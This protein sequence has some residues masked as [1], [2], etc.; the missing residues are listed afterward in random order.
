MDIY[1]NGEKISAMLESEKTAFDVVESFSVLLN[2]DDIVVTSAEVDGTTFYMGDPKLNQINVSDVGQIRIE[3]LKKEDLISDL[4][5][6]CK[7]ILI[8]ISH[9]LKENAF[10]HTK[11]FIELFHWIIET[12]QTIN[13][14]SFFNM[15]EVKLLTSTISQIMDYLKSNERENAKIES[16]AGIIESMIGYLEAIQ[17][18][19]SSNFSISSQELVES[20]DG[21]LTLLPEISEAFQVGKDKEAFDKINR[22]IHMLELCCIYL[23]KNLSS[24]TS[25]EKDEIDNLY[26]EI[27]SLLTQIVEAFENGDAV[28]LGDLLEYELPD[29]LENYKSILL[30]KKD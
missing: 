12:I 24:L 26:E 14:L 17:L 5:D 27:N 18:K 21:S 6:E 16:L 28:L 1:I 7:R 9:D 19:I 23:R 10:D 4:L 25:N 2:K 30:E 13:K 22:I 20:I 11:E 15:V 29:K 8:N 3:A